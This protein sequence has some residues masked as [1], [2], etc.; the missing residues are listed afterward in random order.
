MLR[1]HIR[2]K[3]LS[4]ALVISFPFSIFGRGWWF[5]RKKSCGWYP[6]KLIL[7]GQD[8][9]YMQT[10]WIIITEQPI[11]T[12]RNTGSNRKPCQKSQL[13]PG[14]YWQLVKSKWSWNWAKP[15]GAKWSS[16]KSIWYLANTHKEIYHGDRS[17]LKS[18]LKRG[19]AIPTSNS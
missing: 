5:G 7:L 3:G 14:K 11:Y 10:S 15:G 12:W 13:L 18:G 2:N 9:Y 4:V 19:K 8:L 1:Q 16:F 17:L 6:M